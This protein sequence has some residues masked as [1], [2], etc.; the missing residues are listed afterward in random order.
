[1]DRIREARRGTMV[2]VNGGLSR[3]RQRSSSLRDSPEE[4]GAMEMQEAGR[5]RDRTGRKDRD[6]DR[7]SRNKRRRGD[8]TM[9]GSHREEGED[10][11]DE[12]V[13]ED[14]D[15]DEDDA[16]VAIRLPPPPAANPTPAASVVQSQHLRKGYPAKPGRPQG[17]GWKVTEEMIGAPVPR[18]ARSS[19][20]KRSQE[21]SVSGGGGGGGGGGSGSGGGGGGCGTGGSGGVGGAEQINWPATTSPARPS[22]STAPV[23][24][25]SSNASV[26]KKMPISG[27][28][29][30]PPKT[31]N[32]SSSIQEIEIEVAEVL[33]EM[34]RQVPPKQENHKHDPK[35]TNGPG[36][37]AK[38]RVSSPIPISS[39]TSHPSC[40]PP[41]NQSSNFTPLI[42]TAPKRKRP[43]MRFEEESPPSI[44]AQP[45]TS[46]SSA[47]KLD[48]E[49]PLSS[50]GA[51]AGAVSPRSEKNTTPPAAENGGV[52][53]DPTISI[54]TFTAKV[55]QD[56]GKLE[57]NPSAETND[58]VAQIE[59][60]ATVG[61]VSP[62]K[63]SCSANLDSN[64]EEPPAGKSG[65]V[66]DV[67]KEEKYSIDL[68]FPPPLKSSPEMEN[69][70]DFV[71]ERKSVDVVMAPMLEISKAE[72]EKT[73]R[74]NTEPQEIIL[75]DGKGG[76]PS[77]DDS[78][79]KDL[80]GKE[81]I[82]NL[83]L[84]LEKPDKDLSGAS[85][86]HSLKQQSKTQRT[87][88]KTEKNAPAASLPLPMQISGWPGGFPPFGYVGHLPPVVPVDGSSTRAVQSL[89]SSHLRPKRC[90][91]HCY[92][93]QNIH[94]HQQIT[95]LSPFWPS[96]A[97]A[98]PFPLQGSLPGRI[99]GSVL[100]K[101][102]PVSSAHS[103]LSIKEKNNAINAHVD[104]SQRKP[105]P[106]LQQPPQA[107]S[108]GNMLAPAFI[109][110][111]NQQQ[112]A[113]AGA[114]AAANRPGVAKLAP[115][116]G[117]IAQSANLSSSTSIG[118][119]TT[120]GQGT[121]MSFNYPGLPPSE[122]QYLAF[123]QNNH[124]SFPIPAHVG[125]AQSYRGATPPQAMPLINLSFYPPQMI[126]PSQLRLQQ[127]QP[128]PQIHSTN[129]QHVHQNTSTSS[130][131]SSSPK[132]NQQSSQ[133]VPASG[134]SSLAAG[135]AFHA[136][137]SK[138]HHLTQKVRQLE[139][140]AG[141]EDAPST[142]DSRVSQTQK[143]LYSQKFGIPAHTQNFALISPA[144]PSLGNAGV[145]HTDK[146]QLQ[147]TTN[148]PFAMSF[149]SHGL[150]FSSMTHN[151][152]IFQSLPEAARH[153]YQM[154]LATAA[155]AQQQH[156]KK[157]EEVKSAT[158]L[159][160]AST[161]GEDGKISSVSKVL[162][163]AHQHSLADPSISI[164]S[165]NVID[166]S[167][168]TLSL[169]QHP[170]GVAS[171][172]PS[173]PSSAAPSSNSATTTSHGSNSPHLPSQQHSL[174]QLHKQQLQLQQQQHRV[175]QAS[176]HGGANVYID[177]LPGNS[178]ASKFPQ[179]LAGFP[180][181]L[182]QSSASTQSSQ[183]KAAARA[184]TPSSSPAP[185]LSASSSVKNQL[186]LQQQPRGP[187]QPAHQTQISFGVSPA[188]IAGQQ[189]AG[190]GS[191]SATLACAAN[192]VAGSPQNSISK[193]S[194][195]SPL[196]S[197]VSKS[198]PSSP[199]VLPVLP[200]QKQQLVKGSS[201]SSSSMSPSNASTSNRSLPLSS[202]LGNTH[203]NSGPNS[204]AKV[205]SSSHPLQPHQLPKQ[206]FPQ[207][208][209]QLFFS[210]PYAQSQTSPSDAGASGATAGYFTQNHQRR[211][212]DPQAHQNSPPGSTGM[213]S[214]GPPDP[215]K[216]SAAMPNPAIKGMSA[217]G[218]LQH[219]A[220]FAMVSS[221]AGSAAA[222]PYVQAMQSVPLKPSTTAEQKPAAGR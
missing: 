180:P 5:L 192:M 144:T 65:M 24:P 166:S 110:P 199:S 48:T 211:P 12:S 165:N 195:G 96:A 45:A 198:G 129:S 42:T 103:T 94:C 201:S 108:Q 138:Q 190:G 62:S 55:Q 145:N 170:T 156:H 157:P 183:W 10:S 197:S 52:S 169:I 126:H 68:M 40:L 162:S 59:E 38:P 128:P 63:E 217:A 91:T 50:V 104:G 134:A 146:H 122:A 174:Q 163:N 127:Q 173:R 125:G 95:R 21:C 57:N 187:Q 131:S 22:P 209:A 82:L 83:Q 202:I 215:A 123:L 70:S 11:S 19:S 23:S 106:T 186:P 111:L 172:V 159:S 64:L 14:D 176:S 80:V 152:A 116:A 79:S 61:V 120:S 8:R 137:P 75:D 175:K 49:A 151:H 115:G 219:P 36:N 206:H 140:E 100:E 30:R 207:A 193:N 43:R 25:S 124:Y 56:S 92:I 35:E 86:H 208:A 53:C 69:T 7:S 158:D 118:A 102:G 33:F 147:Q 28:K 93:A 66:S 136:T 67:P 81:R 31:S 132:N 153:G 73:E 4:D 9:H 133:R 54:V 17:T 27:T 90:A 177:R 220:Q 200:F 185:A 135:T 194:V 196:A 6:R 76:K 178:N 182:I 222:F 88:I 189:C 184:A 139:S 71:A 85:K 72:A 1:M 148:Q 105:P 167:N 60:K 205:P 117:N 154:S 109:F 98:A 155:A 15:D 77:I 179:G 150:D 203:I 181:A 51:K 41:S 218:I 204:G 107:G 143:T 188:K 16:S 112:A 216:A 44:A 13:E 37:E 34:T 191:G 164:L 149:T 47:A 121:N 214:L 221:Q 99:L 18:K 89:L 142:A 87:E 58:T 20:A 161:I 26:R 101:S 78:G 213:L 168:R 119:S 130:G 210:N 3:R 74:K 141:C 39:A 114:V 32:K 160:N 2:S 171:R 212:V 113:S 29:P 46:C 84:D 97:G